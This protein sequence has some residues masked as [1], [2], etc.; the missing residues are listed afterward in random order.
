MFISALLSLFSPIS[1]IV[2][3]S[4]SCGEYIFE[5]NVEPANVWV[6]V[7]EISAFSRVS[8]YLPS[9]TSNLTVPSPSTSAALPLVTC[10]LPTQR[11]YSSAVL[12]D[13]SSAAKAGT[14]MRDITTAINIRQRAMFRNFLFIGFLLRCLRKYDSLSLPS[15]ALFI[16]RLLRHIKSWHCLYITIL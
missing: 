8:V 14:A 7:S 16:H 5:L 3:S 15:E 11:G 13:P 9:A 10:T 12:S 1:L 6:L 2:R 4:S